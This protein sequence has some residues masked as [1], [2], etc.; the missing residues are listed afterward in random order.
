MKMCHDSCDLRR[1]WNIPDSYYQRIQDNRIRDEDPKEDK[2]RLI[3]RNFGLFPHLCFRSHEGWA[4]RITLSV[5]E[6]NFEHNNH[7]NGISFYCH[8][9]G[10]LLKYFECIHVYVDIVLIVSHSPHENFS[11]IQAHYNLNPTSI[12]P[13][14]WYLGVDIAKASRCRDRQEMNIGLL[15]L[16]HPFSLGP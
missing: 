2:M 6:R 3:V 12:G 1:S 9:S 5:R 16:M 11:A 4:L 10:F 14:L 8:Q 7:W 13:P 15:L